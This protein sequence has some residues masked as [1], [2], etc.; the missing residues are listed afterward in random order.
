M[1]IIE[2]A[3][4]RRDTP[5]GESNRVE[6]TGGVLGSRAAKGGTTHDVAPGTDGILTAVMSA[7]SIT[8]GTWGRGPGGG[9]GQGFWAQINPAPVRIRIPND[10]PNPAIAA[11]AIC[12]VREGANL[13]VS[14]FSTRRGP[15]PL[16]DS[17]FGLLV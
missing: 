17:R 8:V 15:W 5:S 9:V 12:C 14:T 1:E 11:R 4:T 7:S 6:R 16:F 3:S 10:S 2:P 13:R